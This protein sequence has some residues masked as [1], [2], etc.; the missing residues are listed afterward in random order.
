MKG[1]MLDIIIAG[2][3]LTALAIGILV[4]STVMT[5]VQTSLNPMMPAISQDVLT[6]GVNA[7]NTF[8]YGFVIIMFGMGIA[9]VIF[10]WLVPTHPIFVI[11][12]IIMLLISVVILPIFSNAFE[13]FS[14]NPSMSSATANFPVMTYFM[15]NLP[16]IEV[17]FG[18]LTMIVMYTRWRS[19]G[20]E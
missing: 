7:V 18:A 2:I 17:I 20:Q 6:Q 4:A 5:S 9:G 3:A 1:S 16:L 15:N 12:S 8:N 14:T 11:L 19:S 13:T 10:A